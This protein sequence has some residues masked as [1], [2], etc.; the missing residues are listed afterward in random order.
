M[1]KK[2]KKTTCSSSNHSSKQQK[3][4]A[5]IKCYITNNW[6]QGFVSTT[7]NIILVT[8]PSITVLLTDTTSKNYPMDNNTTVAGVRMEGFNQMLPRYIMNMMWKKTKKYKQSVRI[9]LIAYHRAAALV[10]L[11]PTG[12][13]TALIPLLETTKQMHHAHKQP[14]KQQHN[15]IFWSLI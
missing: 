14:H 5:S 7:A 11:H 9:N 13:Y 8:S 6:A 1:S 4:S 2:K 12:L 10:R 3:P 15:A